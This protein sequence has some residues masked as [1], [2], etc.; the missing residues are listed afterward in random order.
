[1]PAT[2]IAATGTSVTTIP[3][4]RSIVRMTAR[5]FLQNNLATRLSAIGL[6]FHV[7]PRNEGNPVDG[8]VVRSMEM[9]IHA[10]GQPQGHVLTVADS[11]TSRG[12]IS[13]SCNV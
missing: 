11:A 4:G 13:S 3:Q 10:G 6:T 5:S 1:M 2:R 7:S 12:S 8:A 9:V